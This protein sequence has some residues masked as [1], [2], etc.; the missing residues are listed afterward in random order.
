VKA[1]VLVDIQNDFLVG[2]SLEVPNGNE[3]INHINSIFKNYSI[4]VATKDWHPKNHIS[5]ASNHKNKN[6]GEV[7]VVNNQNQVLWP[8]H[9]IEN[10]YGSNFPNELNTHNINKTFYKGVDSLIDSYSGFY[11]NG[12]VRSTGLSDFLKKENIKDVDIVG[13]ATDYCVKYTAI[14]S[15]NDGFKTNVI[16]SCVRGISDKTIKLALKE[17]KE[18]GINII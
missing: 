18:I 12:K 10:S 14:D 7:I 9:C 4:V 8:D 16:K 3:I 5:F 13:L 6:I 17:M 11:D 2:G 15:Y 1:L